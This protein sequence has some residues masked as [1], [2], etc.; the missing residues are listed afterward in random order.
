MTMK[1]YL[2]KEKGTGF[3]DAYKCRLRDEGIQGHWILLLWHW[4]SHLSNKYKS[5]VSINFYCSKA[6]L[7]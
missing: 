5:A 3:T 1:M 2:L 7:G 6:N 4:V